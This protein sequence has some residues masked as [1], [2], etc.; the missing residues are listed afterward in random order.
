MRV[1][2]SLSFNLRHTPSARRVHLAMTVCAACDTDNDG[3]CVP[4]DCDDA[5]ATIPS[6]ATPCP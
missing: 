3:V 6:V 5:D 4:E 2:S 1:V